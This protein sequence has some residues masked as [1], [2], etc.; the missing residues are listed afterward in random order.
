[1]QLGFAVD[2]R[3][4]FDLD[5]DGLA[6]IAVMPAPVVGQSQPQGTPAV[7]AY[8]NLGDKLVPGALPY[9]KFRELVDD[10]LAKT[11]VRTDSAAKPAAAS[12]ADSAPTTK[13]K[14]GSK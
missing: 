11:P 10:E 1:M 6:D 2:T 4:P 7:T 9:D 14:A 12:A 5:G 13:K 8:V 3:H